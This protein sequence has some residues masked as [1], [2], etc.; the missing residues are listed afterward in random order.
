MAGSIGDIAAISFFSNKNLPTGEGGMVVTNRD[1]LAE[2]VR[3]LRSHGMTTFTWDRHK[4]SVAWLD[5]I[6]IP[7]F[8][9]FRPLFMLLGSLIKFA[10]YSKKA[11]NNLGGW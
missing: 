8:E 3:L 11:E 5:A 1:D 4:G 7:I 9:V 6:S 2:R 10:R